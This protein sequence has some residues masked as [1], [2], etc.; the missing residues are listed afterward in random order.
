MR[1]LRQVDQDDHRQM[2][3]KMAQTWTQLAEDRERHID[4][5]SDGSAPTR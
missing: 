3:E 2:L 5:K 4:A 1:L